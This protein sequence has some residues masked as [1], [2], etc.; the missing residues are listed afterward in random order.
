MPP[1]WP[2]EPDI[3][4]PAYR[5][6]ADRINFAVHVALFAACNS[7]AWF[8]RILGQEDWAWTPWLTGT[9]A[10]V[11]LGHAVWLFFLVRYNTSDPSSLPD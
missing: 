1:R 2:R 8:F 9:W 5:K 11:L 7:G 4:D 10:V 3:N 6:L